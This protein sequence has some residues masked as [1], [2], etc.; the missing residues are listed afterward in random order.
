MHPT[1]GVHITFYFVGG[2]LASWL[3]RSIRTVRLRALARG[4]VSCSW[5][6]HFTLQVLLRC[7]NVYLRIKF[8]WINLRW[9]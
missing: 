8:R 9:K 6:K 2:A 7:I 3:V 5:A 1:S 4:I